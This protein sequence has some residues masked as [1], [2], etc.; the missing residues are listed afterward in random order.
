MVYGAIDLR[1]RY[2][3]IRTID[4]DGIV[5]REQRIPASRERLVQAFDGLGAMRILLETGT[6]SEPD[7][8]GMKFSNRLMVVV[9][10]APLAPSRQKAS[11]G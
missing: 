4:A 2:S 6:E 9:L 11:P 3:W 8:G 10:L 5:Q 7:V 1:M